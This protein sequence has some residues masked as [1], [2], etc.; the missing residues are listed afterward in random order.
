MIIKDSNVTES[1][2]RLRVKLSCALK[3]SGTAIK[4]DG[5]GGG[6]ITFDVDEATLSPD[7]V[8]TLLAMR[9]RALKMTLETVE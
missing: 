1:P 3:T 5:E 7:T 9:M 2:K 6:T 4:F 8:T